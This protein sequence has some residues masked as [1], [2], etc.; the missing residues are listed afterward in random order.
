MIDE[1]GPTGPSSADTRPVAERTRSGVVRAPETVVQDVQEVRGREV[2][3]GFNLGS[4][5][6]RWG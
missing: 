6:V 1:R 4:D 2:P 3:D 5:R